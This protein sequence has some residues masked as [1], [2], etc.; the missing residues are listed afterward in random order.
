MATTAIKT[1]KNGKELNTL[2]M[3]VQR[4]DGNCDVDIYPANENFEPLGTASLGVC[5]KN[6]ESYHKELRKQ[7][8]EHGHFVPDFSTNPEWHPSYAE[9]EY[10]DFPTDERV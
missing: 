8:L 4:P 10:L 1:T 6:E 7:A 2:F 5:I 9:K 3:T